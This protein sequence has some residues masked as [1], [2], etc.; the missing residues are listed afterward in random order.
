MI[1]KE[2][3]LSIKYKSYSDCDLTKGGN[4]IMK[5]SK[6]II[7]VFVATVMLCLMMP[8]ALFSASGIAAED[9]FTY[10]ITDDKAAITGFKAEY[11]REYIGKLKKTLHR[12]WN[13]VH[14]D[15]I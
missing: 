13:G 6:K 15:I 5:L 2:N 3:S 10:E 9:V 1:D 4:T 14:A 7:S 8:S 12:I 11:L